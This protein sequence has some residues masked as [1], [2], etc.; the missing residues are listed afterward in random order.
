MSLNTGSAPDTFPVE[1]NITAMMIENISL[2]E[3]L[4]I[5]GAF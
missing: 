2:R 1:T 5:A 3:I 4:A